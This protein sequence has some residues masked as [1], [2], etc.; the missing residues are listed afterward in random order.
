VAAGTIGFGAIVGIACGLNYAC[1]LP[2]PFNPREFCASAF[3]CGVD[4]FGLALLGFILAANFL[5]DAA[6]PVHKP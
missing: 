6:S 1:R 4:A 3:I 2:G 5:M